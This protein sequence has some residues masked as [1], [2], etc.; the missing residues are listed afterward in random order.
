MVQR[1]LTVSEAYDALGLEQV[2]V[3]GR[4]ILD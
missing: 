2:G 1:H 3:I 4:Q